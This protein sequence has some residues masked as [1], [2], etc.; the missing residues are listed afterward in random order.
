MKFKKLI[1]DLKSRYSSEELGEQIKANYKKLNTAAFIENLKNKTEKISPILLLTKVQNIIE[2]KIEGEKIE[3][4][5]KTSTRWAK[6]I[7]WSLIGGTG[8]GIGWLSIAK[9]EEIIS[10]K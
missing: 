4:S 2:K 6:V 5:L 3:V 7:T 9:T 8:F 1:K 10:I